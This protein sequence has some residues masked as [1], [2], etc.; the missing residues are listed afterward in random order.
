MPRSLKYAWGAAI[1][2]LLAASLVLDKGSSW[3]PVINQVIDLLQMQTAPTS[4]R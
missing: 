3:Q 4:N 1:T 2:A